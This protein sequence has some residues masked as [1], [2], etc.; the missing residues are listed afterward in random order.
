MHQSAV[1]VSADEG[2]FAFEYGSVIT[3]RACVPQVQ[4]ECAYSAVIVCTMR[5]LKGRETQVSG[6]RNTDKNPGE[7]VM[8]RTLVA[9]IVIVVTAN[10]AVSQQAPVSTPQTSG[11]TSGVESELP[12]RAES[13]RLIALY[14]TAASH[15]DTS[16]FSE[17]DC[18]KIYRQLGILYEALGMYKKSADAVEHAIR[19][20][21]NGPPKELADEMSFLSVVHVSAGEMHH[22]E[23]E[24]LEAQRVRESTG[25][26]IQ[27]ARGWSDLA[28]VY[29]KE[30]KFKQALE[31]AQKSMNVI[32]DSTEVGGAD[33]ILIRQ[34]LGAAMC[35]RHECERGIALLK[36]SIEL[37]RTT[38]GPDSLA[39]GLGQYL[40]GTA[41]WHFGDLVDAADCLQ[42]GTQRMKKELGWGHPSYVE[43]MAKYA[44]FLRQRGQL[45]AAANAES[46]VVRANSVVDARTFSSRR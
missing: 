20:L 7:V 9:V 30:R 23:K 14:E 32:G 44:I 35:E 24:Q 6:P 11:S 43:A 1:V 13:L 5:T 17:A 31:L 46:E 34:T 29:L 33:R 10:S 36:D 15:A 38:F 12:S 18:L 2:T 27:I 19:L 42:R 37:S 3:P 45:E 4:S 8:I 21:R 25:D 40:L 39:V 22:A 16:K 28:D 41:Y 26:P